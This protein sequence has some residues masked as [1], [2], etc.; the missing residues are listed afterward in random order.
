[1]IGA[2]TLRRDNPRLTVRGVRGA[3]QPWRI[4]L[5]RSGRLPRNAYLFTDR[6]ADRTLIFRK[7]T[8]NAVLAELGQREITSVLIEGGGDLLGQALDAHLID[9]VQIYLGPILTGG[10][11][12]AF[13]GRGAASTSAGLR[14]RDVH[15][16]KIDHNIYLSG[17]A[18]NEARTR[19]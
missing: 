8:L 10:P 5:T 11:V 9:R 12:I 6:F 3:R 4:I 15:Y 18:T 17:R 2:E 13:P 1:M 14:L 19:E 16:E 7:R